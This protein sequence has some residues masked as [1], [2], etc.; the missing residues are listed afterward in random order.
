[1]LSVPQDVIIVRSGSRKRGRTVTEGTERLTLSVCRV[2][3]G[4]EC[5]LSVVGMYL[6]I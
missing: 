3:T 6:M 2:R 5:V 1:M 4:V